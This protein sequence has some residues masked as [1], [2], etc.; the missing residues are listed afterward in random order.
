MCSQ[1]ESS[2]VS[3]ERWRQVD[4]VGVGIA[5]TIA[6]LPDD[7]FAVELGDQGAQPAGEADAGKQGAALPARVFGQ[8]QLAMQDDGILLE[9]QRQRQIEQF[10]GMGVGLA[11]HCI[12]RE[13][14]PS[15]GKALTYCI[16]LLWR[17]TTP[18]AFERQTAINRS[19][20]QY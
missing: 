15:G 13:R 17:M 20:I 5:W 2:S 16:I 19:Q 7:I 11:V 6:E 14:N 18:A 10:H 3:P 4:D 8:T 12:P 1:I 9:A